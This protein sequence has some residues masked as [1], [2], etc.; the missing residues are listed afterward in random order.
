MSSP[1]SL[2]VLTMLQAQRRQLRGS[3]AKAASSVRTHPS[4]RFNALTTCLSDLSLLQELPSA[5]DCHGGH[6][7]SDNPPE[8]ATSNHTSSLPNA[9][10]SPPPQV[11]HDVCCHSRVTAGR[12]G[13]SGRPRAAPPGPRRRHCS[14]H[15]P[16]GQPGHGHRGSRRPA[17][18]GPGLAASRGRCAVLESLV[19]TQCPQPVPASQ[20]ACP[21]GRPDLKQGEAY[22]P[23]AT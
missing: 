14:S 23:M 7:C 8:A 20:G 4:T 2:T 5:P 10:P 6:T 16:P 22:A 18:N 9:A 1:A 11:Q 17:P 21:A 12:C 15:Q 13:A 3:T 19:T